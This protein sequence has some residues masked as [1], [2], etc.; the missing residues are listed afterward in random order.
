M[1]AT[2]FHDAYVQKTSQDVH[3]YTVLPLMPD[4]PVKGK[5]GRNHWGGVKRGTESDPHRQLSCL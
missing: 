2:V 5:V 3:L 1:A 4:R